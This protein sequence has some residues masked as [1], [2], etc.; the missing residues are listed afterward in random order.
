MTVRDILQHRMNVAIEM[1]EHLD[2]GECMFTYVRFTYEYFRGMQN[3]Y[4]E[5]LYEAPEDIL[6]TEIECKAF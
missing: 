4:K 3:A 6:N 1:Q 2:G 5:L